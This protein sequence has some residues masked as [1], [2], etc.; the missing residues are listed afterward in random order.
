MERLRRTLATGRSGLGC[1]GNGGKLWYF[2]LLPASRGYRGG[3]DAAGEAAAEYPRGPARKGEAG[4]FG[5]KADEVE[6]RLARKGKGKERGEVVGA[7]VAS[8][9]QGQ[10]C[11]GLSEGGL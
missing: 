2:S 11:I 3:E 7:L 1:Y 6:E 8:L 4:L 5:S 9:C 10:R